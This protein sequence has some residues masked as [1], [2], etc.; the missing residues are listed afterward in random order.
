MGMRLYHGL[1]VMTAVR[2]TD[3]ATARACAGCGVPL[4][5]N[6]GPGR[7]RKWC[8][9][10]C[11][12]RTLYSGT[13]VECGAPTNN[14]TVPPPRLCA[15][16]NGHRQ[17]E[18]NRAEW[19]PYRRLVEQMWAEGMTARQI[20]DALGWTTKWSTAHICVLRR[21]QGYNLPLRRT[22]EQIA[23]MTASGGIARARAVRGRQ[24]AGV[25]A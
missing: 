2:A 15:R 12:K 25:A 23:R 14:G 10:R 22:P 4:A 1:A 21:Q 16:C 17:G 20:A 3:E 5:S 7:Q 9:E 13:C 19:E 11:R 8:S 6:R 18:A 24:R